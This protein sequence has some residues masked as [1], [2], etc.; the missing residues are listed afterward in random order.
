MMHMPRASLVVDAGE[1]KGKDFIPSHVMAMSGIQSTDYE[2]IDLDLTQALDYLERSTNSLPSG[3][4]QGWYL[5]TYDSTVLGWVKSTQ[6]GLKNHYPM[7]WRLR[8]RKV[9]S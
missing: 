2:I 8:D 3:K 1:L 9:K 5:V 6:Q 7:N 4:A